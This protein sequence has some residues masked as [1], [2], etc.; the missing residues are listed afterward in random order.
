[1]NLFLSSW[2]GLTLV[3][4]VYWLITI[5]ATVFF[6][7]MMVMTILGTDADSDIDMDTDADSDFAHGDTIPFQFVSFKNL[8]AFF[9]VFGWSGIG[10]I[11]AGL[12]VLL[13]IFLSIL[14][15]LIMMTLM[16]ALFYF[17]SKLAESGTLKMKNAIGRLGEVYLPIPANRKGIGK[18]QLNVQGSLRTLDAITDEPETLRTSSII[19][20]LDVIDD[21]ILLVK[22]QGN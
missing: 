21:Q 17:M 16:A 5:P 14:C 10:F 2:A 22:K 3:E 15:G 6:L 13:T 18:V 20:V 7:A 19:Q 8:T 12:S 11:H 4:Q 9:A 1:M